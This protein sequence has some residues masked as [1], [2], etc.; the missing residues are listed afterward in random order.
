MMHLPFW[1]VTTMLI[2]WHILVSPKHFVRYFHHM[3]CYKFL[4]QEQKHKNREIDLQHIITCAGKVNWCALWTMLSTIT[5]SVESCRRGWKWCHR[6]WRVQGM[7]VKTVKLH[8]IMCLMHV[9]ILSLN[10]S[11]SCYIHTLLREWNSSN[12]WVCIAAEDLEFS[13]SKSCVRK[14]ERVHGRW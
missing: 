8:C 6:L 13:M 5:R 1:R 3:W 11:E 7:D 12:D 10:I 14:C 4:K 9:K 2:L